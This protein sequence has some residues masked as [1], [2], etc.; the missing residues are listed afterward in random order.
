[1]T[2]RVRAESS[3]PNTT[4]EVEGYTFL[5][6]DFKDVSSNISA[7]TKRLTEERLAAAAAKNPDQ[8]IFIATHN[9]PSGSVYK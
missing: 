7:D 2:V 3:Q 9:P 6:I 8:P 5:A 1:M 4:F